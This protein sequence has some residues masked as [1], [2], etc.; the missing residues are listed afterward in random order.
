MTGAGSSYLPLANGEPV[1]HYPPQPKRASP[2]PASIPMQNS[3]RPAARL[4]E[5]TPRMWDGSFD[6]P[7]PE[8]RARSDL[9]NTKL[10]KNQVVSPVALRSASSADTLQVL[11]DQIQSMRRQIDRQSELINQLL[12][13]LNVGSVPAAKTQPTGLGL[14][15]DGGEALQS[16]RSSMPGKGRS[17]KEDADGSGEGQDPMMATPPGGAPKQDSQGGTKGKAEESDTVTAAAAACRS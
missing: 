10:A 9:S 1:A 17:A 6:G 13:A 3:T 4:N 15:R 16:G 12:A 2:N 14:F 5:V 7:V 8:G 11:S